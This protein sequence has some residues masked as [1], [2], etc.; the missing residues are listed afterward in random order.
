MPISLNSQKRKTNDLKRKASMAK[1]P[2]ETDAHDLT[3]SA[4]VDF[5]DKDDFNTFAAQLA[6]YNPNRFDP[7]ALRVFVQKGAPIVTLYALDT[8]KQEQ[9][10]YPADKLPV[11]KFKL[12]ISWAEFFKYV[13]RFDFTVSNQAFD[14]QDILVLNK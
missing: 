7:V 2:F 1:Q 4:A 14:L 6:K 10:D 13:K 3:G 5:Y 8:Q 12:K 9:S 11:K